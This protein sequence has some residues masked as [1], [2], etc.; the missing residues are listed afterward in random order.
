MPV[1]LVIH[2]SDVSTIRSR[3]ALVRIFS[4]TLIPQPV[5]ALCWLMALLKWSPARCLAHESRPP[6]KSPG[7]SGNRG[8]RVR[9]HCNIPVE[10]GGERQQTARIRPRSGAATRHEVDPAHGGAVWSYHRIGSEHGISGDVSAWAQ[11]EEGY[12]YYCGYRDLA[13]WILS[14][15]HSTISDA[16]PNFALPGDQPHYPPHRPADV[17]H[18]DLR[19]T[20][21]F[22]NATVSGTATTSFTTLFEQVSEISF[23]A[24]ELD[25]SRVT[26]AGED[27][28]LAF[29]TEREKLVVRLPRA[30]AYGEEFAVAIDYSARPRTGLT[31]VKPRPGNPDLPGQAWTQGEAEYHHYWFPCHDS[32]NDR[33]TTSLSAT[34]PGSF[35]RLSTC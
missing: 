7:G 12:V 28:P 16:A 14:G 18:V 29:W 15:Q 27:A 1:R 19:V 20:L 22:D 4:G 25:I 9:G 2:S 6:P 13:D 23:D 26:L 10:S 17:R 34:L 11:C 32:P 31:F 30:Y 21:D 8:G 33:A 35:F 3:W 24:A 5:I